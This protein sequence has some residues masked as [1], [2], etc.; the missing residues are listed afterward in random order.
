MGEKGGGGGEGRGGG[1]RGEVRGKEKNDERPGWM[2][3][4]HRLSQSAEWRSET[5]MEEERFE[6]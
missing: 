5:E 4:D 1:G 2:Y 3:G 6:I